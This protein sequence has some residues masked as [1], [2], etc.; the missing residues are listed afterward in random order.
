MK[1]ST[2]DDLISCNHLLMY[3]KGSS[4]KGLF[5]K[6]EAFAFQDSRIVSITDASHAADYDVSSSGKLLGHR[7]Q[8]GRLL[9]LCGKEFI[10]H[11]SGHVHILGYHSTVVK[12]VCR[13][14]LQAETL[15]MLA[16]YEEAEHVRGVLHG[17]RNTNHDAKMIQAMDSIEIHLLTDC[18]SL[19]EHPK[20]AGLHTVNDKRLAIDLCGLRQLVWQTQSGSRGSSLQ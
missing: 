19:E 15:S 3:V 12:R 7:S 6:Y 11:G 9:C 17:L 14:T 20:Q 5:F 8:S 2:V 18:R 13:S 4:D 16:G 10:E 1:N